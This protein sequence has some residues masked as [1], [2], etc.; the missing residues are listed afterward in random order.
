[1]KDFG[2]RAKNI[3]GKLKKEVYNNLSEEEQ[4]QTLDE[5]IEL[6]QA[7]ENGEASDSDYKILTG[8]EMNNGTLI[9]INDI[10]E[11]IGIDGLKNLIKDAIDKDTFMIADLNMNKLEELKQQLKDGTIS[12]QDAKMLDHLASIYQMTKFDTKSS[13]LSAII[14][15]TDATI[16]MNALDYETI[17]GDMEDDIGSNS[18]LEEQ[19]GGKSY[20][21]VYPFIMAAKGLAEAIILF[22]NDIDSEYQDICMKHGVNVGSNYVRNIAD[23]MSSDI[24]KYAKENDIDPSIMLLSLL[25][26]AGSLAEALNLAAPYNE[27]IDFIKF[28]TTAASTLIINDHYK[29]SDNLFNGLIRNNIDPEDIKKDNLFNLN[30]LPDNDDEDDDATNGSNEEPDEDQEEFSPNGDNDNSDNNTED[31]TS[32]ITDI[33]SFL[34]DD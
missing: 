16:K 3:V 5:F 33:R 11:H 12:E 6:M 4:E 15:V 27:D 9:H 18:R 25:I 10:I 32:N 28:L 22:K 21:G 2:E 20:A 13:V 8:M 7:Y 26:N 30:N 24:I 17:M 29:D 19:V 23:K 14:A 34:L 31:T 1:M